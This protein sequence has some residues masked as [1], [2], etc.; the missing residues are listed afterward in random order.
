MNTYML[1]N[2]QTYI[3]YKVKAIFFSL[4]LASILFL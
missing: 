2:I 3:K 4:T 1:K